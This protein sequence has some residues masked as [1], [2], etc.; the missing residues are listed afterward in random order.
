MNGK[1]EMHVYLCV[2]V[3]LCLPFNEK[4]FYIYIRCFIMWFHQNTFSIADQLLKDLPEV[5][6]QLSSKT[7]GRMSVT[8]TTGLALCI[9][10]VLRKYHANLLVSPDQTASAFDR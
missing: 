2:F 1:H 4:S 9:V 10:G 3:Y 5:G 6:N 8:Y 7:G